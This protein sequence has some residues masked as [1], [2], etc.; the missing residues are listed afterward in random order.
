MKK[1]FLFLLII[2]TSI[3]AMMP[4]NVKKAAII[5]AKKNQQNAPSTNPR[6]IQ[7]P[8]MVNNIPMLVST[9]RIYCPSMNHSIYIPRQQ[10]F[11][12][13]LPKS[14]RVGIVNDQ[15]LISILSCGLY[16]DPPVAYDSFIFATTSQVGASKIIFHDQLTQDAFAVTIINY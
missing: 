11:A 14:N 9:N 2:G 10:P 13:I 3:T 5:N 15:G 12:I 8:C 4:E 1:L 7:F 16:E 6:V